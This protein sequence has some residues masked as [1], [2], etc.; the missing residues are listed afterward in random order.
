ME[1]LT[2]TPS[3][4]CPRDALSFRHPIPWNPTSYRLWH[5]TS[6]RL[7]HPTSSHSIC[8]LS[9][10]LILRAC[11]PSTSAELSCRPH[12]QTA[13]TQRNCTNKLQQKGSTSGE[14]SES[15]L[16]KAP[17]Q[18]LMFDIVL[19]LET[20]LKDKMRTKCNNALKWEVSVR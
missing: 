15:D 11:S 5:P 6:Y 14:E 20:G 19:A 12:W 13:R 9:Y 17:L 4:P 10:R 8:H 18:P 2:S 3:Y 7:W 16:G 1:P